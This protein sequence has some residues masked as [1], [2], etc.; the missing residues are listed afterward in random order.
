VAEQPTL[1]RLGQ[2]DLQAVHGQRI[3]RPDVDVAPLRAD[4]V[5]RNRHALDHAVRVALHDG[6]IHECTGVAL[7]RIADNEL[8]L[9]GIAAA[10][11]PLAAGGEACAAAAAQPG[12]LHHVDDRLRRHLR[13]RLAEGQIAAGCQVL[14]DILR[15]DQAA[16]AQGDALLLAVERHRV[17]R[18]DFGLEL[19]L[20]VQQP[21]DAL[22]ADDMHVNDFLDI[23][24][25]DL[26]VEDVVGK[27]LDDGPFL[28]EAKA[29]RGRGLHDTAQALARDLLLEVLQNLLA[30]GGVTPGA[31]ADQNLPAA[32]G[33][34]CLQT[35]VEQRFAARVRG[36][37]PGIGGDGGCKFF[38][39]RR[40]PPLRRLPPG[41]AL[42]SPGPCPAAPCHTP[43]H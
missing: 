37:Q 6:A 31:A 29:A 1:A 12:A 17:L 11:L 10:K 15:I 13:Q 20:L 33:A 14:V 38:K 43:C 5:A 4:G 18:L 2:R 40:G 9:T 41:S 36:K 39:H 42:E 16:V 19:R 34:A 24:R 25:P 22:V 7:V 35:T 32:R 23:L 30:L 28:A 8:L 3:L 21:L 26:H 27:H